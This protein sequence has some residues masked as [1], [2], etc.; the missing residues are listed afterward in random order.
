MVHEKIPKEKKGDYLAD[1][2][3]ANPLLY[4]VG[5]GGD[6]STD[7][8]STDDSGFGEDSSSDDDD[9]DS[10][11]SFTDDDKKEKKKLEAPRMAHFDVAII[12]TEE[13]YQ[14]SRGVNFLNGLKTTFDGVIGNW[15]QRGL[16]RENLNATTLG[17]TGQM[18]RG[19][20]FSIPSSLSIIYS[21]NIANDNYDK[22]EII[23]RPTIIAVDG[24]TS[25]FFSGAIFHVELSA[26][27][28]SLGTVTDVPVGV[29]LSVKPDFIDDKSMLVKVQAARH[30]VEGRDANAGFQNF[31]QTTKNTVSANVTLGF[32]E[33]LIIAGLSEKHKETINDKVPIIGDIP[34]I[35]YFFSNTKEVDTTKSII[36]LITPRDPTHAHKDGTEKN[37]KQT[38]NNWPESDN[39]KELK[40]QNNWSKVTPNLRLVL[41]ELSTWGPFREYR[42]GDMRLESWSRIENRSSF[43]HHFLKYLYF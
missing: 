6:D 40:G 25:D 39:L 10:S 31:T 23:A 11:M 12:R 41:K 19:F 4:Q 16:G 1:R 27:S 8:F 35:Q 43:W 5:F 30:Y 22:N 29:H 42:T 32:D 37:Q 38:K 17:V 34:I 9:S 14:A 36:I 20:S 18:T 2:L 24:K 7:P 21:L 15:S 13:I 28:G 3:L 26:S 33:T